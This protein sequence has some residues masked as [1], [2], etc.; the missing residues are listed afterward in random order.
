LFEKLSVKN[1]FKNDSV[2]DFPL[3]A[4]ALSR[5]HPSGYFE[6]VAMTGRIKSKASTAWV[7]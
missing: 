3:G 6:K 5:D 1:F 7:E 4:F 2:P